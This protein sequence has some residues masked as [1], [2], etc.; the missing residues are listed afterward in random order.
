MGL[1]RNLLTLIG[2]ATVAG[3]AYLWTI[4]GPDL[5][6]ISKFDPQAKNVYATMFKGLAATGKSADATVWKIPLEEDISWEDAEEAMRFVANEHNIKNVGEL[7]LS[8]QVTL[9]T[10]EEQRFLKIYQFCNP[11][12]AAKMVDYSDAFSAYLP[13][14]IAMVED[15]N[16]QFNLY[17][18]NMDMMIHG[19]TPLPPDLLE[20]ANDVKTIM[21]DIMKR[22]AAGEF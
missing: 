2:L 5:Q 18:L 11:L 19:G 4:I 15:K 10:G 22:G 9:M 14:R 8:E 16:G 20:A 13:C 1:I 7:P 21:L 3:A 12:T 6:A 17:S